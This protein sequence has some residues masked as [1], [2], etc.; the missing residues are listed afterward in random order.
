MAGSK[1]IFPYRL[2]CIELGLYRTL[3]GRIVISLLEA[4]LRVLEMWQEDAFPRQNE[5]SVLVSMDPVN[6]PKKVQ[7]LVPCQLLLP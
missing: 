4:T 5:Y 3:L 2:I 7:V 1:W 6:I